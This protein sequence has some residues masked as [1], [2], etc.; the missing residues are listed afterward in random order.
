MTEE[1]KNDD[2]GR[3][4]TSTTSSSNNNNNDDYLSNFATIPCNAGKS[5]A[6]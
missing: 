5:L 2:Y 4:S 3:M 1:G 6:V